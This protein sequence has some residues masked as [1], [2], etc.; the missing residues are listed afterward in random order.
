MPAGMG[1]VGGSAQVSTSHPLLGADFGGTLGAVAV[2]PV[3][4]G[5][6]GQDVTIDVGATSVTAGNPDDNAI[7]V[8]LDLVVLD[9][10][11]NRGDDPATGANEAT[12][13]VNRATVNV[14]GRSMVSTR[15]PSRWSSP[16]GHHQGVHARPGRGQRHRRRDPRGHQPGHLD[17]VRHGRD[18]PARG[19][20]LPAAGIAEGTTPAG[21]AYTATAEGD[22]STRVTYTG[23]DIAVGQTVTF[24]FSVTLADPVPVPGSIVNTAVVSQ[25]TTLPTGHPGGDGAERDEPDVTGQDQLTFTAPDLRVVKDDGVQVRSPG[26]AYDYTITVH[27]D[28]GRDATGIDLTDNLPP[29]L[30]FASASDGGTEA[31]GVV[32]WPAFDLA[33]GAQRSF[34]VSVVVDNPLADSIT[35]FLNTAEAADD[36]THGA[37]PVD[38]DRDSDLDTT[39]AAVDVAVTKDDGTQIRA[40]GEQY[41]YTLD[42][43]NQGNQDESGITLTDTLR[44]TALRLGL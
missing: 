16:D 25:A 36:G 38:N 27:N 15:P 13:L 6:D 4:D 24:T 9:V 34:T 23:G 41:T 32:S 44:R 33:A 42:V 31:A 3:A 18:R 37:D 1:Y 7:V 12:S 43:T 39:D 21:F 28:G 29:G 11:G 40:P 8:S 22:N 20:R 19:R 10:A 26:D 17:L 14:A 35:D 5:A 2:T 30:A